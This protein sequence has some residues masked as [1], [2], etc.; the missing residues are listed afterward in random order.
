MTKYNAQKTVI[1]GITFDS[2]AESEYYLHLKEMKEL[3]MVED[4]SLQPKFLLQEGFR[5]DGKW[6]RP[7][8]YIADFDIYYPDGIR[9]VVDV[10]GQE[11]AD[12]KIKKKLFYKKYPYVTLTLMK[13]VKKYGGWIS[14][15]EWK[16]KKKVK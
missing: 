16:L 14:V 4:F 1:D 11:T 2:K 7:I 3:G 12:F 6:I 13:Y 10:K 9:E 5:K 15:D 8:H